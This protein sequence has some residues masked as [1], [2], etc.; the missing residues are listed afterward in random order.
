MEEKTTEQGVPLYQDA[1][2]SAFHIMDEQMR[3]TGR[4]VMA[5]RQIRTM[6]RL[7]DAMEQNQ[8]YMVPITVG[9]EVLTMTVRFQSQQEGQQGFFAEVDTLRYGVVQAQLQLQEDRGMLSFYCESGEGA[10]AITRQQDVFVATLNEMGIR[11]EMTQ[12]KALSP[13]T[14]MERF[15]SEEPLNDSRA[16]VEKEEGTKVKSR[17]L[18]ESA[19]ALVELIRAL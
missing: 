6:M 12:T 10:E 15:L 7:A 19:K 2:E 18:Y 14:L 1:F 9:D 13:E 16:T 4:D 3:F 8:N 11:M 5:V 17:T